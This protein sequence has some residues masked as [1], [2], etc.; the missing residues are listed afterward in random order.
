VLIID[1][2][3]IE[4]RSHT[5]LLKEDINESPVDESAAA[6]TAGN[7]YGGIVSARR[8]MGAGDCGTEDSDR[9]AV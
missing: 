3:D 8:G 2:P 9:R 1:V 6:D 5:N 4:A 7:N